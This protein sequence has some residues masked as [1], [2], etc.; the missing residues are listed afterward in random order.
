MRVPQGPPPRKLIV[1]DLIE[2]SGPAVAL[3]NELAVHYVSVDYKTGRSIEVSW[4][5]KSPFELEFGPGLEIKGWEKG[6]VGMKVG[7]RRKLIIPSKLAYDTGT[8]V[9]VIDLL[10]LDKNPGA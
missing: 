4:R 5:P 7:G 3:N 6:L 10:R 2:G 9:Y 8:V 1:E